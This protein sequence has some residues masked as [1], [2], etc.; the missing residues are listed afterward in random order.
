MAL[1]EKVADAYAHA[2]LPRS[3]T[4]LDQATAA[5]L[6][7]AGQGR[8]D[9][10]STRISLLADARTGV[11]GPGSDLL[12]QQNHGPL[13]LRTRIP[14]EELQAPS[15]QAFRRIAHTAQQGAPRQEP[16]QAQAR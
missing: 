14:S 2:G 3:Q 13:G 9:T 6:L 5:V 12:L 16:Q 10:D 15:D 11:I 8:A 1:R 7:H 4:Q